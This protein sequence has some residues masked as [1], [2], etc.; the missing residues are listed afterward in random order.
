MRYTSEVFN[1][2][3]GGK[4][5]SENSIQPMAKAMYDDVEENFSEYAVY[6]GK[7]DFTLEAGDGYFYF[8]R[9]E[10]KGSTER[11]L[12]NFFKW[13]DY[14]DFLKAYDNTFSQGTQF[15]LAEME[16]RLQTNI[17]MK[18]KLADL[19]I[20]KTSNREKLEYIVS[21]LT[22]QGFAEKTDEIRCVY[23]VTSAFRYLEDII[24]IININ[25]ETEHEI[26]E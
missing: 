7:I 3:S 13:I 19:P 4:F 1:L 15:N 11:K 22:R 2:L 10:A 25:E 14:L 16:T 24:Q 12:K 5:L 21:D 23:Q 6:F 17:E 8:S 9:K 20:D 26:P 18:D